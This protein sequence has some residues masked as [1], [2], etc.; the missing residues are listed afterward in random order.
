MAHALRREG[1]ARARRAEDREAADRACAQAAVGVEDV[2]V[3]PR[4]LRGLDRADAEVAREHAHI[5]RQA[6]Q[7]TLGWALSQ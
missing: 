4:Q 3:G 6:L 7:P 2:V 5:E 1:V